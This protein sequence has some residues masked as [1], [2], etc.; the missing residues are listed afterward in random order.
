MVRTRASKAQLEELSKAANGSTSEQ[1]PPADDT[2]SEPDAI[3]TLHD[4]RDITRP[5]STFS[6]HLQRFQYSEAPSISPGKPASPEANVS[7]PALK[8]TRTTQA[9][10]SATNGAASPSPAK[11]RRA[12]SKYAP[13]SKYSHLKPL[14]DILEPNL[15]CVFVGFNPGVRTATAG[16]AYAH[17]SNLFWKLLHSS[18]CT[19][20]LCRPEEDVDLPRLYSMG[21]TNLVSRPSKNEAELSKTEMAA[22]T[23]ILEAKIREYKPEAVCIVGKGIWEAIWR[24]RYGRNPSKA[25]FKYGW[26]DE[27]ENMGKP[28]L[29]SAADGRENVWQGARVFVATATSGLAASTKPAEKEAIWR[30]FGQWVKQ[31]REE[32][33][34]AS[35]R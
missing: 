11:K 8:R 35:S 25:D 15:I 16:H 1:A 33:S 26:Q 29:G 27:K 19:D 13:P 23:P 6:G 12:S 14:T 18:G 21:N 3:E 9:L 4:Q 20:R 10:A 24:Y 5:A 2:R 31:R 7:R 17:P 28:E 34:A 32:R 30:P 22:G